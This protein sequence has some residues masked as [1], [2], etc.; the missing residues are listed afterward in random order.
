MRISIRVSNIVLLKFPER[1]NRE[2]D[3][4]FINEIDLK[5]VFFQFEEPLSEQY[6]EWNSNVY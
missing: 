4:A 5:V 1:E 6:R 2:R 3:E